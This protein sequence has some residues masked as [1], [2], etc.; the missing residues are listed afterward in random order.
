MVRPDPHKVLPESGGRGVGGWVGES[1]GLKKQ[2]VWKACS[3]VGINGISTA[4]SQTEVSLVQCDR[5][6][7]KAMLVPGYYHEFR[8]EGMSL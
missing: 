3:T 6:L 7:V 2:V 5:H 8:L 1:W 4:V